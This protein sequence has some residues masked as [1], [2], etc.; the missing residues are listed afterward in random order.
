M[1]DYRIEDFAV[2]DYDPQS[3]YSGAGC[4]IGVAALLGNIG[5]LS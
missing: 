4:G 5:Q 1:F 2:E 3:A